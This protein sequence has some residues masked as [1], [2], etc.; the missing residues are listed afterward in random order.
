MEKRKGKV[1]GCAC[2]SRS[3]GLSH[4]SS[5]YRTPH[6]SYLSFSLVFAYWRSILTLS[7]WCYEI[8]QRLF[9]AVRKTDLKFILLLS[10]RCVHTLNR[11]GIKTKSIK[12][13]SPFTFLWLECQIS[14]EETPLLPFKSPC[15]RFFFLS[16][17]EKGF[18]QSR[19]G[20]CSVTGQGKEGGG[21]VWKC[22]ENI[23]LAR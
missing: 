10:L 20:G 17:I 23:V 14:L 13:R 11:C 4:L 21:I 8:T 2:C 18:C 15:T 22:I 16:L 19:C 5:S 1:L 9:I 6:S 3:H 7:L 12:G